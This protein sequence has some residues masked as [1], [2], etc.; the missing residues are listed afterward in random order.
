[1]D[2]ENQYL[3]TKSTVVVTGDKDKLEW[4]T[5]V[6]NSKLIRFY[7]RANYLSSSMGGGINF[8]PDLI[9]T[10]PVQIPSEEVAMQLSN[11]ASTAHKE[12]LKIKR[13]TSRFERLLASEFGQQKLP[14]KFSTWWKF[15]FEDFVKAIKINLSLTQKDELWKLFDKYRADLQT[16]DNEL[17]NTESQID[18]TVYGLY[19]LSPQEL[20]AVESGV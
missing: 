10:L 15:E 9:R 5:A 11:L 7:I 13:L 1:M 16:L 4:L 2:Y 14:A 19:G 17:Q 6:L 3:S 8:T 20:L 18:K 12:T